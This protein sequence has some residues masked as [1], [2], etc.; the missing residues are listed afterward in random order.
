MGLG[1]AYI[2]GINF[3]IGDFVVIMDA[4]LSHHPK[5]LPQFIK[6]QIETKAD[7]VTGTRYRPGGGVFGW[8]FKRKLTSRVA[9]FIAKS[10]LGSD[11]T[12]LTGS[13]RLYKKEVLAKVIKDVISRGYAFQMK[14]IIRAQDYGLTVEEVTLNY[15]IKKVPIVFVDRIFGESKLGANEILT[16]MKGVWKLMWAF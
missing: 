1:S 12:D 10:A 14:I 11:C 6:K 16:Y 7:I 5:Y 2:D 4:D 13:Y 15:A 8:D 3:C 9:N